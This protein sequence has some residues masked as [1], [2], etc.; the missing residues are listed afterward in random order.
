MVQIN[1]RTSLRNQQRGPRGA[2]EPLG[3]ESF[4]ICLEIANYG[5][6]PWLAPAVD[7]G[8]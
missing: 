5:F 6:D 8:Q 2:H 7:V 3:A 1:N 4:C